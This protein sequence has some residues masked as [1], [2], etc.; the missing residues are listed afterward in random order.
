MGIFAAIDNEEKNETYTP[1][2]SGP[3]M[4]EVGVISGST[5]VEGNISSDGHLVISGNVE[6][7]IVTKGNLVLDGNVTGDITC[8]S[9]LLEATVVNSNIS[10]T[11][12]IIIREGTTINGNIYCKNITVSGAVNGNINA[13][14]AILLKKSASV[15]GD[16]CGSSI[17]METG[18]KL[19]GKVKCQ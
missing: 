9:L 14:G 3:S 7:N 1:S 16:L 11:A 13:S 10:V 17:G 12:N 18:A 8:E 2:Y 15:K 19:S 4:T 5:T 6:G